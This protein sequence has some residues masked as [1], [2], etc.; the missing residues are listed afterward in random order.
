MDDI[1]SLDVAGAANAI[2]SNSRS[3]DTRKAW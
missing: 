2:F 1:V 3:L